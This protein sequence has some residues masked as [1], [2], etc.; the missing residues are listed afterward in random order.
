MDLYFTAT[1]HFDASC[2]GFSFGVVL[3]MLLTGILPDQD[4]PGTRIFFENLP[5]H[6]V[7][8]GPRRLYFSVGFALEPFRTCRGFEYLVLYQGYLRWTFCEI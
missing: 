5:T 3:L 6:Q 8:H 2:D 4:N 7:L 1:H